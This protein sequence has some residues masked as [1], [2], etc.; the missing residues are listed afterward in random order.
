M[1]TVQKKTEPSTVDE[2]LQVCCAVKE[3]SLPRGQSSSSQPTSSV[4]RRYFFSCAWLHFHFLRFPRR[5][6]LEQ[7]RRNVNKSNANR[8]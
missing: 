8:G 4:V 3:R 1:L 6:H 7:T 2:R 5:R